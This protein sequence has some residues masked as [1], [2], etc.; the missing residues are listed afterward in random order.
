MHVGKK[1]VKFSCWYSWQLV[2][3]HMYVIVQMRLRGWIKYY[4]DL[5]SPCNIRIHPSKWSY[6][7]V[8]YDWVMVSNMLLLSFNDHIL[9][10]SLFAKGCVKYRFKLMEQ[11][12]ESYVWWSTLNDVRMLSNIIICKVLESKLLLSW[13]KTWFW[14]CSQKLSY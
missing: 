8:I 2:K 5:P 6:G 9:T 7:H 12:I 11:E 10:S 13:R 1:N 14:E 4:S 3:K